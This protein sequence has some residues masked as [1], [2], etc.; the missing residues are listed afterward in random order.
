[1]LRV[2]P[3]SLSIRAAPQNW[4]VAKG[5]NWSV[6]KAP[7]GVAL[8]RFITVA[9]SMPNSV[10]GVCLG[11]MAFIITVS[12]PTFASWKNTTLRSTHTT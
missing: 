2:G 11:G 6:I 3:P 5:G 8:T 1:M 9:D 10:I 12:G 4:N 7:A